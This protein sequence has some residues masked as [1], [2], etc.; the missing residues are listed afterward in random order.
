MAVIEVA[1]FKWWRLGLGCLRLNARLMVFLCYPIE[2]E[3]NNNDNGKKHTNTRS[4]AGYFS[5]LL[6]AFQV[7]QRHA[8][9]HRKAHEY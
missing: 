8:P 4:D 2:A 1:F 6:Y 9:K 5:R 7:D 3:T